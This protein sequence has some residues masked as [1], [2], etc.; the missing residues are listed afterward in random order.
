MSVFLPTRKPG[1]LLAYLF[2]ALM[3]GSFASLGAAQEVKSKTWVIRFQ[4]RSDKGDVARLVSV[5]RPSEKVY[6]VNNRRVIIEK[7]LTEKNTD[8]ADHKTYARVFVVRMVKGN[9]YQI[10]MTSDDFD[11]FLFLT[12]A[13]GQQLDMDD[14]SGG[15]LNSQIQFTAPEDGLYRIAATSYDGDETGPYTLRIEQK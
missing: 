11:A 14:D 4:N 1:T 7:V 8:F 2:V 6:E 15:N 3:T 12:D 9:T 13:N 10:D 5:A